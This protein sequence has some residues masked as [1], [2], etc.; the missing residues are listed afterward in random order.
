MLYDEKGRAYVERPIIP[1]EQ[2]LMY[3]V[4]DYRRMY[5]ENQQLRQQ[6]KQLEKSNKG[7]RDR[8]FRQANKIT[9]AY[10]VINHC[11]KYMKKCG[12][13]PSTF[14]V[15]FIKKHK[16]TGQDARYEETDI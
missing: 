14:L 7:L 15:E 4:K 10:D 6:N 13:E 12:I 8:N 5:V 1:E 11:I 2:H 3:I 16:S 9:E